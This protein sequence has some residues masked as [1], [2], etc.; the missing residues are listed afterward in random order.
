MRISR[1]TLSAFTLIELIVAITIFGIIMIS[2]MSIFTLSS[3]MS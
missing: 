2:V 1:N 3:Q